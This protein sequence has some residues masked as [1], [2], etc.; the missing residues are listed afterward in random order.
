MRWVTSAGPAC[1]VTDRTG[2]RLAHSREIRLRGEVPQPALVPAPGGIERV[3]RPQGGAQ[4]HRAPPGP[5]PG[6]RDLGQPGPHVGLKPGGEEHH[7]CDAG[8]LHR[9]GQ[10]VPIRRG[11]RKGLFKQQVLARLGRADGDRACTPGGTAK[12]TASTLAMNSERSLY[13]AA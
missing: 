8:L 3:T 12:A 4:P 10:G 5:P 11:D 1:A 2:P 7:G 13:A 9:A 6:G